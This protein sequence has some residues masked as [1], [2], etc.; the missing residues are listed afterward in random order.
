M[1]Q[2]IVTE[3]F[4]NNPEQMRSLFA[5]L[6]YTKNDNFLQ[7]QTCSMQ[8]AN[9]EMLRQIEFLVGAKEGSL[10]FVDGSGSFVMNQHDQMPAQNVCINL[11]DL[12]TQW[13]GIVCLSKS[14]DPHFINFYKNKKTGWNQI[15]DDPEEFL[16]YGI[17]NFNDFYDFLE[18]ENVDYQQKWIETSKIELGFNKLILFRPGL[19]HSYND[20]YGDSNETGRLL[21]FFF[22]KSKNLNSQE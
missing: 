10:D 21:Q 16:K 3:G 22:I 17:N 7:G 19:F 11:P 13:V 5:N 20:V 6:E 14:S 18:N 8:F 9:Q 15:P 2:L 4:Y 12:S 1:Q